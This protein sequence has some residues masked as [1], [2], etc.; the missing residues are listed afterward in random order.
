[1][2]IEKKQEDICLLSQ[3]MK[4]NI[5]N[6]GSEKKILEWCHRQQCILHHGTLK[7][8]NP[9]QIYRLTIMQWARP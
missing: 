7:K 1:M 9:H 4:P 3:N 6:I 8:V 2:K 5:L